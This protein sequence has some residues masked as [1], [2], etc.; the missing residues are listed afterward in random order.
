MRAALATHA[1]RPVAPAEIAAAFAGA[2]PARI[3]EW[4]ATLVALGQARRLADGR[5]VA[6]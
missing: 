3:A 4:L 1:G 5:F 2:A 6:G